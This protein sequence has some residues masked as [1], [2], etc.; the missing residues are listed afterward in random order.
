MCVYTLAV[1]LTQLQSV[2]PLSPSPT[3]PPLSTYRRQADNSYKTFVD[4]Q[5]VFIH[6]SSVLTARGNKP[7]CVVYNEL[8]LTSKQYMRDITA[9]EMAWLPELAPKYFASAAAMTM[10][11]GAK[12]T[13]A[14]SAGRNKLH[15]S[16]KTIAKL[17]APSVQDDSKA[18]TSMTTTSSQDDQN[19]DDAAS[20][21]PSRKRRS[22]VIVHRHNVVDPE[23]ARQRQ[24]QKRR[25]MHLQRQQQ[26]RQ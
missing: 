22:A 26:A 15:L 16:A 11:M 23:T 14:T 19:N 18:D 4:G 25:A 6:P 8:I 7:E 5:I 12:S 13:Q 3:H 21:Q 2:P 10:D 20:D 1:R 9:V 17:S 24:R